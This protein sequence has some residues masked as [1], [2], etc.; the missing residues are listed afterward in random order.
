[1]DPVPDPK[2]MG[3]SGIPEILV[4]IIKRKIGKARWCTFIRGHVY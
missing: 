2:I 4:K 3:I 1:V